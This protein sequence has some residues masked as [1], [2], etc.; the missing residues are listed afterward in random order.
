M[1]RSRRPPRRRRLPVLVTA[2][3]VLGG[4]V[5]L[6]APPVSPAAAGTRNAVT[7]KVVSV[8]DQGTGLVGAVQGKPFTVTV[9][10]V[11]EF[12]APAAVGQDTVVTL[13]QVSGPGALGGNLTATI[14]GGSSQSTISGAVYSFS[15]NGFNGVVLSV[16]STG[17][18]PLTAAQTTID[19]AALAT[20]VNALPRTDPG[21][22]SSVDCV[23]AT[24]GLP[25]CSTLLLPNG[26]NGKVLLSE[27]SC[28]G[29]ILTP[30]L[31]CRSNGTTQA[32]VVSAVANFKDATGAPLY[33][34]A[35]P[36]TLIVKCDQT[37][38][39]GREVS[40]FPL[41]VDIDDTGNFVTA[42]PCPR[43][44]RIELTGGNPFC[45]DYRQS[46][47]DSAGDLITYLLFAK[48]VRGSHP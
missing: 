17:G 8:I 47:R 20:S 25:T 46:R 36:A 11:D 22:I 3:A 42:A 4:L 38:C 6:A 41:I 7:L 10:S 28:T 37:L 18:Q 19:V 48:D 14:T 1:S 39:T 16:A 40:T 27:G 23:N 43:K 44:G 15:G 2:L 29:V 45:V 31:A 32:L 26:A 13:S 30:G 24:P 12:G 33:T 21:P 35:A 34:R 5:G 9:Q